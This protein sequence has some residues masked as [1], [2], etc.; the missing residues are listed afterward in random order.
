MSTLHLMDL[1]KVEIELNRLY[2]E[3]ETAVVELGIASETAAREDVAA[4]GAVDKV[5]LAS[6]GSIPEKQ[7]KA[8]EAAYEFL[9]TA[10]VAKAKERTAKANLSRIETQLDALRSLMSFLKV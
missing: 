9:L 1:G 10:A 2:N 6:E 4:Q 3:L 8:R 5:F 7:A